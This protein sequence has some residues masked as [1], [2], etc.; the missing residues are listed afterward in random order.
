[1]LS[2]PLAYESTQPKGEHRHRQVYLENP[3]ESLAVGSSS[4]SSSAPDLP[5]NPNYADEPEFI[6]TMP[7]VTAALGRDAR[8][9]C[10]VRN[11]GEYQVI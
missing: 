10:Y 11:L 1:M 6:E 9:P 3:L 7:N 4:S 5:A 2:L 8:I